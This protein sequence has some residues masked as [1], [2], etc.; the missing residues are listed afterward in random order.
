MAIYFFAVSG[1]RY[2]HFDP[3]HYGFHWPTR[4]W[5]VAHL[6][7]GALALSLG[8][9]QFSSALRR[10]YVQAHRWIGRT[11]L[12]GVLV[13]SLAAIY[14][15]LNVSPNKAFGVA[16]LFLALAWLTTSSMAYIAVLHRQFAAH[17]EWMIR[18]YVVTF[19][20][21]VFR[22]LKDLHIFGNLTTESQSVMRGWAAWAVP[23]LFAEVALQWRRTV[24][25]KSASR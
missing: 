3:V 15:S 24:G 1:A 21:V 19:A 5:L 6:G 12:T 8:P 13:G 7:G 9:L 18:S 23:L 4:W 14:M 25:T 16:L 22:L 10:R 2:R 20:F 11:Y 17:R